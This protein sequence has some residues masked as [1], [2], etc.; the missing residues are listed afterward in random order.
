MLTKLLEER[1]LAKQKG[2]PVLRDESFKLLIETALKINPKRILEIGTNVGLSGIA[3]LLNVPT[4][5]LTGIELDE[6]IAT[7]AKLNYKKYGVDNR[8]NLFIGDAGEIVPMLNGEFDLI[9]LDGPKS[10]YPEYLPYIKNLLS[11]G[12]V[13]FTDNV[14]FFG[15]VL[16][17]KKPPHKHATI[18]N[19]LRKF[20]T[21]LENDKQLKTTLYEIEDG[22]CITEKL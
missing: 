15:Y 3:M 13:L 4:A 2:N 11:K 17:G 10:H 14:L 9:F 19:G 12:G 16:N 20:L 21:E 7:E 5:T 8:V 22:V 1:K 18:I 6:D